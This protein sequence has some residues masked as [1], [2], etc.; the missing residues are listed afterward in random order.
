M[1]LA[2]I[3]NPVTRGKK[4][5]V[6]R[7]KAKAPAA[8][9]KKIG[10]TAKPAPRKPA[11]T[12]KPARSRIVAAK[13]EGKTMAKK[14]T[15]RAVAKPAARRVKRRPASRTTAKTYRRN[16]LPARS[17]AKGLV[18]ESL[19]PAL[20]GALGALAIDVVVAKLPLPDSLKVGV[21]RYPVRAA[22]A[23]GLAM[24]AEK[25]GM[26]HDMAVSLARGGLTVV[27][28]DAIKSVMRNQFP[29]LSLEAYEG[30]IAE[31]GDLADA[32]EMG[33]LG[34]S[35]PYA[36]SLGDYQLAGDDDLMT[37]AGNDV[38]EEAMAV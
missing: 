4:K 21:I 34:Q 16:P 38:Y 27:S 20:I 10:V 8:R 18:H 7:V 5:R 23:I 24:L 35:Y 31:I 28:Y 30:E 29:A 17:R 6:V 11:T 9:K 33:E 22:G 25:M 19:K 32:V 2:L 3:V 12:A 37:I 14:K 13:Q 26:R 36:L 1:S 15:A